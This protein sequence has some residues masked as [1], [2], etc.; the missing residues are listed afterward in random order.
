MRHHSC[1]ALRRETIWTNLT[2]A[3]NEDAACCLFASGF[4]QP[5]LFPVPEKDSNTCASRNCS[6]LALVRGMGDP[7]NARRR[8]A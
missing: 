7:A 4:S 3:V 6:T 1:F 5:S 8:A 2:L